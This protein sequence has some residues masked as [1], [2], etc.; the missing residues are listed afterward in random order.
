MFSTILKQCLKIYLACIHC[1]GGG[2][3]II[4]TLY[5]NT[6]HCSKYYMTL[7]SNIQHIQFLL[8]PFY[9]IP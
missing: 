6:Y 1:R 9:N 7:F 5:Y 4:Y 3:I 2:D 8:P